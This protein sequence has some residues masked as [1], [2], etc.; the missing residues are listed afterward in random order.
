MANGQPSGLTLRLQPT[1]ATPSKAPAGSAVLALARPK[2]R[3]GAFSRATRLSSS[4]ASRRRR[5]APRRD[6]HEDLVGLDHAEVQARLFLDHFEPV[7]E[8]A[9][10][11]IELLVAA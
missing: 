5:S 1:M 7:L 10:L 11:G 9:H 6:L 2:D 4:C 3:A 8:I